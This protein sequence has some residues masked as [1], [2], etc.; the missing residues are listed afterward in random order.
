[1]IEKIKIANYLP[2]LITGILTALYKPH[3][4]PIALKPPTIPFRD[5]PRNAL[6]WGSKWC[7]LVIK[8]FTTKIISTSKNKINKSEV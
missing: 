1:M 7:P 3:T 2:F 6:R 5:N 4:V 8:D